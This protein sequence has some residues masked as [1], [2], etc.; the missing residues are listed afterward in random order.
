MTRIN[1]HVS[2]G[3]PVIVSY[4]FAVPGGQGLTRADATLRENWRAA[5]EEAEKVAGVRFVEVENSADAMINVTYNNNTNGVSWA[6]LPWV[7]E[8]WADSSGIVAMNQFYG[9]YV[10]GSAGFQVILHELGH[11]LGLKHP[12]DGENQLPGRFDNT[13]NTVMSYEWRGGN[14][15]E[16]QPYDK[17][18]LQALYGDA[19]AMRDVQLLWDSERDVLSVTGTAGSDTLLGVNDRSLIAGRKGSDLLVGRMDD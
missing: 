11:A 12:H 17:A 16:F 14:K 5:V 3:A 13:N 10:P 19:A 9:D 15:S 6:Y 4:S 18:A 2:E 8:D 7:N 1:G